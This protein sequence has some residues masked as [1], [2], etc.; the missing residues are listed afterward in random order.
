M[1]T[2][3]TSLFSSAYVIIASKD[4]IVVTIQE[5]L[6]LSYYKQIGTIKASHNVF[7][8]QHIETGKLYVKKILTVYDK[9]VY[10]EL[11][12]RPIDNI[13][14]IYEV[15]EDGNR[16]IVIEEYINGETIEEIVRRDGP[17]SEKDAVSLLMQ[18]CV[19]V[20]GLHCSFLPIIHRDIKPS[21]IIVSNDGVVKLLDMNA[22]KHYKGTNEEDTHLLGTV[23][24]AAPEQYGFGE[25]SVQTDIYALGV[26]L[27]YLVTGDIPKKRHAV[28]KL[29]TIIDKCTA[30][31]PSDRYEN[32]TA[33]FEAL[34]SF[35]KKE[36]AGRY[37]KWLPPG[38]RSLNP[39]K[40]LLS[41]LVYALFIMAG[42]TLEVKNAPSGKEWVDKVFFFLFVFVGVAFI[43][44][45]MDIWHVFRVDRVK[46]PILRILY[47]LVITSLALLLVIAIMMIVENAVGYLPMRR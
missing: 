14:R 33:L 34:E 8:V 25:S 31:N 11:Q 12:Q 41:A 23:G 16:L 30:V 45:Y 28:G 24:F 38:F 13:P 32:V 36:K 26:L 15:V 43:A 40:M 10:E 1:L 9:N 22:A 18:L 19:I 44:N 4:V 21:N 37:I 17:L 27:N 3:I 2:E 20:N 6:Q 5:E 42:L 39:I 46:Q 29:C 47:L 35:I 7:L